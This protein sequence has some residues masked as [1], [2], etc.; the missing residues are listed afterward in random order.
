MPI[1][2]NRLGTGPDRW[3][4]TTVPRYLKRSPADPWARYWSTAQHVSAAAFA[5]VQK[6]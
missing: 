6:I 5:V 2:W 4:L 3:T 1:S